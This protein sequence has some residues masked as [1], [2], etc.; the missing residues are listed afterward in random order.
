[1]DTGW[2]IGGHTRSHRTLS[3]LD[4]AELKMEVQGS[5]QALKSQF[6]LT[7]IPFAYPYGEAAHIGQKAPEQVQQAGYSCAVTTTPDR[8]RN[9]VNPFL[10]HRM[11]DSELFRNWKIQRET[12]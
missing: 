5:F 3:Q 2:T 10:L 6:G 8:N 4:D 9:C 1:M 11:T 7:E 12:F